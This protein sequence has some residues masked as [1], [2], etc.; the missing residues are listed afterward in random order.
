MMQGVSVQ[1]PVPIPGATTGPGPTSVVVT[2]PD[3]TTSTLPI[4]LTKAEAEVIR[5]RRGE[6]SDQLISASN[7]REELAKQML[8][9]PAGPARTGIE[10]RLAVLDR[11]LAQLESDIAAT[12]R[13]LTAAAPGVTSST[14]GPVNDIPENVMTVSIVLTI[15]VLFPLAIT[16][17]RNLWKRGNRPAPAAPSPETNQRLERLEQGV[18][19]IAIEIERVSEG[20]RFV[21]KLLSEAAPTARLPQQ[22]KVAERV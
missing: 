11:R 18:E 13:Q 6:L 15:F 7:R 22:E 5:D 14:E 16:F 2:N 19:A 3:G 9:L 17:A 21:T 12:G 1:I 20:Q 8:A 4:P 10:G